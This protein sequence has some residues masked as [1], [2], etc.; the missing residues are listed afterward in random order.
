MWKKIIALTI[1]LEIV[2]V[3]MVQFL[4]T[5][6]RAIHALERKDVLDNN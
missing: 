3:E 4:V 5:V 1:L 2:V 6:I